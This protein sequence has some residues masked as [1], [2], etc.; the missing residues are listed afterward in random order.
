[1][2]PTMSTSTS[3]S[4]VT[5]NPEDDAATPALP[6]VSLPI[7][8][9]DSFTIS[10]IRLRPRNMAPLLPMASPSPAF[11]DAFLTRSD[12]GLPIMLRRL[13]KFKTMVRSR[14]QGRRRLGSAGGMRW[15][16][17]PNGTDDVGSEVAR[18]SA[19]GRVPSSGDGAHRRRAQRRPAC[20][21]PTSVGPAC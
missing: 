7:P 2:K 19:R 8:L 10:A 18:E 14:A 20:C 16:R 13:T 1:M 6:F 5:R 3:V 11:D 15:G 21:S 17:E 4:H 9:T 12:R